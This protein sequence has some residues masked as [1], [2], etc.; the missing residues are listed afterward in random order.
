MS[1]LILS[2]LIDHTYG[3]R[4]QFSSVNCNHQCLTLMLSYLREFVSFFLRSVWLLSSL[5]FI[6]LNYHSNYVCYSG[7]WDDKAAGVCTWLI[8]KTRTNIRKRSKYRAN[9]RHLLKLKETFDTAEIGKF[10]KGQIL[11]LSVGNL[12]QLFEYLLKEICRL[13]SAIATWNILH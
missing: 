2:V 1:S 11:L 9:F 10:L 13:M 8:V 3:S 12:Q 6:D 4:A 5:L 7:C